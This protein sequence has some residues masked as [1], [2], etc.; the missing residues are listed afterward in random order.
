MTRNDASGISN[1]SNDVI[2]NH[3][4]PDAKQVNNFKHAY[5]FISHD[6]V[7][8]VAFCYVNIHC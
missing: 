3:C 6:F 8:Y 1:N 5:N 7:T 4:T 2:T